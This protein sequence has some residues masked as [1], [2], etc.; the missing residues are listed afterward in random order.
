MSDMKKICD[1][2]KIFSKG[3]GQTKYN[4]KFGH[5]EA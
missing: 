4:L 5:C 3:M 2:K 1:M